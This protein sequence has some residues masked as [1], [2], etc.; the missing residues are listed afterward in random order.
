[1]LESEHYQCPYCGERCEAVLDLSGGDQE[2]TEDCPVCCKP[3]RFK[4]QT[5]GREWMLDVYSEN[6]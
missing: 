4:L 2:Y 6:E 5:D 3:I 1:M